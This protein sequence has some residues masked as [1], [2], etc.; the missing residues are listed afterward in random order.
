MAIRGV[1]APGK[2]CAAV[3]GAARSRLSRRGEV[4]VVCAGPLAGWQQ[5]YQNVFKLCDVD[6]AR[7]EM[8]L[9]GDVKEHMVRLP[10]V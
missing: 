7:K 4:Q 10:N 3:R 2:C 5:P 9:Q 8:E 1:L 6:G